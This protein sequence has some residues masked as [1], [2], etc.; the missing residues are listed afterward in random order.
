M[1]KL[2]ELKK[3]GLTLLLE[4]NKSDGR[5]NL[6]AILIDNDIYILND[7]YRYN[8]C[9]KYNEINLSNH[10]YNIL[11][12][13]LENELNNYIE[14]NINN[15]E[16]Y[17]NEFFNNSYRFKKD[18]DA[19][20]TNIDYTYYLENITDGLIKTTIDNRAFCTY[21]IITNELSDFTYNSYN[22]EIKKDSNLIEFVYSKLQLNIM[23]A[24]KQ[25]E[26]NKAHPKFKEIM[27]CNK[28]LQGKKSVKLVIDNEEYTYKSDYDSILFTYLFR[29]IDNKFYIYDSYQLKPN[30]KKSLPI[31]KLQHLKYGRKIYK[32]N[33]DIINEK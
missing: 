27:D 28:F 25:Y 15:Y 22:N 1:K 23:L 14:T 18:Y 33:T 17:N 30:L 9:D 32:I 3:D 7:F 5:M 2:H 26:Q 31:E 13:K 16:F 12:S 6:Y 20:L 29:F 8:I 10:I 21:N 11:N 4:N 24:H 19:N